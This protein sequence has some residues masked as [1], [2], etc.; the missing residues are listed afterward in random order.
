MTRTTFEDLKVFQGAVELMVEVYRATESYP[1]HEVY[2]LVSQ[3]RRAA[4]SVVS[5]ISEGQ[6]RLT[7]GEWRQMLSQGRGSLFELMAQLIASKRLQYLD[8]ATYA[9]LRR[10]ADTV[11][12][13]LLG[14]IRYVKRRE[15]QSRLRRKSPL[16]P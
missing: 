12:G 7:F 10:Q 13:Q 8:E 14:L 5:H 3:I 16:N 2:G 6:G 9:A 1:K 4:V 15:A 11:G